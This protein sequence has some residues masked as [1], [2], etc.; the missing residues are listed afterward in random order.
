MENISPLKSSEIEALVEKYYP[1]LVEVR[2]RIVFTLSVFAI[3]TV[4]GFIFYEQ[5][6]KF[7]INILSLSNINLVFTSPFQFINLAIGCGVAMGITFSFPLLIVQVLHFLK[8]ALKAKEYRILIMAIPF[9]GI[10][11]LSGFVFGAMVMKWQ[12][13]IFLF[14]SISLGI[15]NVLDISRLLNT[16][17]LTSVL[18]GVS[19]QFPIVLLL[20]IRLKI[21]KRQKLAKNRR[22]V[23]LGSFIFAMLLPQDSILADILLALPLVILFELALLLSHIGSKNLK[24]RA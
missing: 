5:I 14:K 23:Y 12:I 22:W 6:V 11:F 9:S 19:F 24:E 18:M 20:L 17:L 2:K 16:V 3:S 7:L 10:L 1:F 15:G 13:D 8:P 21:V 4:V